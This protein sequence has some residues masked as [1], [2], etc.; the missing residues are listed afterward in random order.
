MGFPWVEQYR[1]PFHLAFYICQLKDTYA[2]ES[3]FKGILWFS[4][5]FLY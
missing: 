3:Y 4:S 1:L 2:W 5:C